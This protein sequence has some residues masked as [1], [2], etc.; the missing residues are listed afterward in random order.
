MENKANF[1]ANI[2]NWL[3]DVFERFNPSAFR[4]LAATLPYA[5]PLPVAAL[6]S[7]SA[8]KFLSLTPQMSG[9]LVYGLEG[10]GLWFTS[11][12]VD[13]V[14]DFV[15]SRN[16]KTGLVVVM[17]A[18]AIAVYITILVN[19]NVTLEAANGRNDPSMSRV[20]TLLCF[21]PL[22]TGIGNG[23][24]KVKLE[25]KTADEENVRIER[26]RQERIRLEKRA[27]QMA[28]WKLKRGIQEQPPQVVYE[29]TSPEVKERNRTASAYKEKIIA[30]ISVAYSET[31]R[32]PRVVE[33]TKKFKLDYDHAKGF[34]S[35]ERKKWM[36]RNG[37]EEK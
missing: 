21:L 37:I 26:D 19:L 9:V 31:G 14:V 29:Q 7:T 27:D 10:I 32:V 17:F 16:A 34:V 13:S 2:F 15:R 4:F 23:Y 33:I 28:R 18:V 5:T 25:Y 36:A 1:L 11:M 12:F 35:T 24:Y 6:T 30:F 3:G 22:V 8:S 20:I